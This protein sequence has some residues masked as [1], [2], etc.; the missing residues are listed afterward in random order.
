[1]R[2]PAASSAMP[3]GRDAV[4]P[5]EAVW[6]ERLHH[7][8]PMPRV[9]GGPVPLVHVQHLIDGDRPP[10]H[11]GWSGRRARGFTGAVAATK[12]QSRM[13]RNPLSDC[14]GSPHEWTIPWDPV[15]PGG[16]SARCPG[17]A[18]EGESHP[19][20]CWRARDPDLTIDHER[21]EL[22]LL[23]GPTSPDGRSRKEPSA[24]DPED[25]CGA[26]ARGPL[27]AGCSAPGETARRRSR[28]DAAG[29][30]VTD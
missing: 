4:S 5:G 28:T 16:P 13:M 22:I 14:S 1:M 21:T 3:S 11:S 9:F 19:S 23:P 6:R 8:R 26:A 2:A 30:V 24:P 29:S 15:H 17:A 12:S 7:G 25:D 18:P 20:T 10:C 27:E